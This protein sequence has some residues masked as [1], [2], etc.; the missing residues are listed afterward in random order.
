M[1]QRLALNGAATFALLIFTSFT[2]RL[3]TLLSAALIGFSAS[4]FAQ[5]GPWTYDSVAMGAGYANDVFYD[6]NQGATTLHAGTDWDLAF[7]TT[8]FG[9]PMFNACARANHA[10]KGVE[11]YPLA[12]SAAANFATL[13]PADTIGKTSPSMQLINDDT[14]WGNGAFY[15]D[16]LST[17]PFSFGWGEYNPSD[18]HSVNGDR[19][20]IIKMGGNAY[21]FWL[22]KYVSTPSDDIS[23][24]FRI[25]KLDGTDDNTV[26]IYRKDGFA[27]RLFAYYDIATNTV[28]NREPTRTSWDL[29]FTQ[30]RQLIAAGPGPKVPYTLTGVLSNLA[31]EIADIRHLNPDDIT[32]ANFKSVMTT[33]PNMISKRTDEVGADWKT[34]VNPGPNGYYQMDDSASFIIKSKNS[35]NYWQLQFTRFDG[36]GAGG[37]KIVF[38][39]RFIYTSVA[40]PAVAAQSLNAFAVSPNPA[41]ADATLML[42]AKK[43]TTAQMIVTDMAGRTVQTAS[44][45]LKGGINAYSINTSAW[46]AGI[47]A[48][49]VVA[50]DWKVSSRV[51]VAH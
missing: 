6:L 43:A 5:A 25:A 39:K 10:K 19:I 20:Y 32:A 46:P 49:Q 48:V 2:M 28:I 36:G 23:Y 27:D 35:L 9:E 22:K 38:R 37:G 24:T 11:V 1:A 29:L 15:Q 18:N 3:K 12:L 34:Y 21:K 51:V 33:A 30:Y 4:A 41:S 7:Q 16:H 13:T 26:V 47:Y 45:D 40:V 31:T 8:R 42:D 14:S 50:Q 44:L 17:D